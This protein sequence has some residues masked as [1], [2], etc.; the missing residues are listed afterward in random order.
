MKIFITGG[1]GFI[2]SYV[3]K[4]LDPQKDE[5]VLLVSE[6]EKEISSKNIHQNIKRVYGNLSDIDKWKEEVKKFG[7]DV[8]LHLAW[9]GI[10]DYKSE[11]SVKNLKYGLDLVLML[12]K[13]GCKKFIGAGSCWEYGN[14]PGELNEDMPINPHNA[15]TAAKNSLNQ[16]GKAIAEENNM[17]FIWTRFFY[18]YG[19]GQKESSLIPSIIASIK[20]GKIPEIKTPFAKNDFIYVEDVADALIMIMKKGNLNRTYN[21][22]S[23]SLTCV[24]D[25]IKEVYQNLG[26]ENKANFNNPPGDTN[27]SY[28]DFWADNSRIKNEIGWVPKT[29]IKQGIRN[30]TGVKHDKI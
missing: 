14:K 18:V 26:I 15:F 11:T 21:I 1:T 20:K 4:K 16:M 13:I 3:L 5:V 28:R 6:S 30:M 19:P 12:S 23:G 24:N 9:E 27:S 7:P 8:T 29:A 10:P 25:I 22:G 17:H 2:G